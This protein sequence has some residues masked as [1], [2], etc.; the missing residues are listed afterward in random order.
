MGEVTYG[1]KHEV[2]ARCLYPYCAVAVMTAFSLCAFP[3]Y[4]DTANQH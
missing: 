2:G 1:Y 4:L 3:S